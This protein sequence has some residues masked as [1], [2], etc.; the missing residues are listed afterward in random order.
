[1]CLSKQNTQPWSVGYWRSGSVRLNR[2]VSPSDAVIR[3]WFN[4]WHMK[5][6]VENKSPT[7]RP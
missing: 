2:R 3:R 6:N 7:G 5:R 1:M 4:Q